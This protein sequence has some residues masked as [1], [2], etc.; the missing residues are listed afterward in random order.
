MYTKN[1]KI[2]TFLIENK[3]ATLVYVRIK[4]ISAHSY[5]HII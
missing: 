1:V 5:K 2:F 3:T 4:R